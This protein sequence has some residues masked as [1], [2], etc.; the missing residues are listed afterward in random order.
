[1]ILIINILITGNL[2]LTIQPYSSD[3]SLSPLY[4]Y[5]QGLRNVSLPPT[6]V[7]KITYF[8]NTEGIYCKF[9]GKFRLETNKFLGSRTL[10]NEIHG[11]I[12]IV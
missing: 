5:K 11:T 2:K 3:T 10:Y 9:L 4:S 7:A 8:S 12:Q 1:M 6:N